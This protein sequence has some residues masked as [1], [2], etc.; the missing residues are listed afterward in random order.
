MRVILLRYGELAAAIVGIGAFFGGMLALFNA[1]LPPFSSMSRAQTLDEKIE[2]QA[3]VAKQ[4]IEA[5]KRDQ[6]V[7]TRALLRLDRTYWEKE[8]EE[9]EKILATNP[10]SRIAAERKRE[11]KQQIDFIDD[12]LKPGRGAP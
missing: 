6:N 11:A 1:D 12:Q 3:A 7:M 4:D 2:T 8:L 9:A 10:M 5:V